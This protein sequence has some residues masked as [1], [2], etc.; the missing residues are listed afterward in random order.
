MFKTKTKPKKLIF[1]VFKEENSVAHFV[2]CVH[3]V[4]SMRRNG[5]GIKQESGLVR[6]PEKGQLL[7]NLLNVNKR[8][9]FLKLKS[10]RENGVNNL[11]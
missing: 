8:Q 1:H 9:D 2:L 6:Q 3:F 4:V 11:H 10:E 7:T 5:N